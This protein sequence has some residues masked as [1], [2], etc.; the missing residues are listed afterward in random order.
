M[1]GFSASANSIDSLS[2]SHF[3]RSNVFKSSKDL[4]NTS[5]FGAGFRPKTQPMTKNKTHPMKDGNHGFHKAQ[6]G[7]PKTQVAL[8]SLKCN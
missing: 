4:V 1:E 6:R 2:M 7:Q 5:E 8:R 3:S